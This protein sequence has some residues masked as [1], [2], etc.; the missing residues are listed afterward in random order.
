MVEERDAGF[1]VN[2]NKSIGFPTQSITWIGLTVDF[3]EDTL[4]TSLKSGIPA[5][6]NKFDHSY[7]TIR[8]CKEVVLGNTIEDTLFIPLYRLFSLMGQSYI[9]SIQK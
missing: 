5:N 7:P 6:Y 8:F 2:E 9:T 1:V 3:K 4:A